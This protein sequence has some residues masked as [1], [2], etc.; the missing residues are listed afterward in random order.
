MH[1][2]GLWVI[3][4]GCVALTLENVIAAFV[5]VIIGGYLLS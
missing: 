2:L 4:A 1:S 3:A 5:L